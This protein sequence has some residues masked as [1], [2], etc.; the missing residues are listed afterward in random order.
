M[1]HNLIWQI[2]ISILILLVLLSGCLKDTPESEVLPTTTIP[3][4]EPS[5]TAEPTAIPTP[6]EPTPPE[7]YPLPPMSDEERVK[8]LSIGRAAIDEAFE[9][10]FG[11]LG[12]SDM[13]NTFGEPDRVEIVD[14]I[15]RWYYEEGFE[16]DYATTDDFPT[17]ENYIYVGPGCTVNFCR[18]IIPGSTHEDLKN[19]YSDEINPYTSTDEIVCVGYGNGINVIFFILDGDTID[20]IYIPAGPFTMKYWGYFVPD[21]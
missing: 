17:F 12:V 6:Q 20:S 13:I 15:T 1:K 16:I 3:A 10:A 21:R 2:A 14:D 4:V 11:G 8:Y 19:A 18:G 7:E 5:P 9:S